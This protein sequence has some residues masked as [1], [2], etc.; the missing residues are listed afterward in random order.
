MKSQ[1]LLQH[2][3]TRVARLAAALLVL[4][5][6]VASSTAHAGLLREVLPQSYALG[7][8]LVIKVNALTSQSKIMKMPWYSLPWC[9]AS[10]DVIKAHKQAQNLGETLWGDQ[11]EPSLFKAEMLLNASCRVMCDAKPLLPAELQLIVKRIEENYR[12]NLLLDGLPVAEEGSGRHSKLSSTVLTGFPIGVPKKYS[13]SGKTVINNHLAFTIK[14]NPQPMNMMG[15]EDDASDSFRIVGFQVSPQSI[16]HS[17]VACND[18]F[19]LEQGSAT[20][21][22]SD[23]PADAPVT[24]SYSIKWEESE[25]EWSTRW[26]VYMRATKAENRIHW[27]SIVNS[28]LIVL[29]LTA[30]I[31]IIL[32]RALRRDF[33][34]Y[35]DPESLEEER[36]ETGW[37]L[38]HGDVFRKPDGAGLLAVYVGTGMQ[39]VLMCA[40]TLGVACAG[41]MAP[42]NR[43]V[44]GTTLLFLFVL[45]GSYSGYTTARLAKMFKMKSWKIVFAVALYF[46]GQ[47]FLSYFLLNLVHWGNKSTTA[48]PFT[49][50]LTIFALWFCVSL[51]LVLLGGAVGYR[52]D[53][54]EFPRKVNAIARTIPPQPWYLCYPQCVLIPGILPFGAA[55]IESV[56]VL[57]TVWQGRIYYVF[58]FL[59]LVFLIVIVTCAEATV[60]MIY[61]QLLNLDYRWWWRSFFTSGSYAFWFFAYSVLYYATAL[62]IRSWW[63]SVLYFG[64]TAMISYFFFVMTG[65]IGFTAAFAFV[66]TIYGSIK[67]D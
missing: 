43:R 47:M 60:V 14:Y 45:L 58:G 48:T 55:F 65:A 10:K 28:L 35:N 29:L 1:L 16:D 11:I 67:V 24:W 31:A 7:A 30:V 27:F 61:F 18:K 8:E 54:I 57:S 66:R 12:G 17:A 56:F 52:R 21:L 50:M 42:G 41:F 25:I 13:A 63:S 19:D 49:A 59:A 64:Y 2:S 33:A 20:A 15:L 4:V 40:V 39:L 38:V 37:K 23:S 36:E 26:D 3:R 34:R 9:Q 62:S 46:P 44:L 53:A 6:L 51:P 22:T 5:V 32:I